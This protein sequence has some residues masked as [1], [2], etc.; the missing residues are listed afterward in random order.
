M[1][2]DNNIIKRL[3]FFKG[4]KTDRGPE[5]FLGYAKERLEPSRRISFNPL[6]KRIE[7]EKYYRWKKYRCKES[8]VLQEEPNPHIIIAGMSGLGKSSLLKS[9]IS[10]MK[11]NNITCV[12]F[13]S[14]SE[15]E[16]MVKSLGGRAFNAADFG[17]NIMALDGY[18]VAERIS[19][20]TT[21]FQRV[22]SLGSLQITK[23]NSCLW[24][25]YR[26]KGARSS[27]QTYM[28]KQPII[29]DLINE[30]N[31]F[32]RNARTKSEENTLLN[33]KQKLS[34][35]DNR[36]LQGT[37]GVEE[38]MNGITSFS[39][40]AIGSP[41]SR[42]IYVEEL[43][44]RLYHLMHKN[45]PNSGIKAYVVLDESQLVLEEKANSHFIGNMVEEG[46]KYG[47]GMIIVAHMASGLDRRIVAN[48][49]ALLSFFT[50]EPREVNYI[51]SV[52]SGGDLAIAELLKHK[53]GNLGKFE[54]IFAS[55]N[56]KLPI[57]L[58]TP[59]AISHY[60]NPKSAVI[61]N[62]CIEPVE[63]EKLKAMTHDMHDT[64][65]QQYIDSGIIDQF[66]YNGSKWLMKHN[67]SLSI[68]HEVYLRYISEKLGTCG[69]KNIL[70]TFRRGPDIIAGDVAIEYETGSK[71]II[72]T[73]AMLYKR[74]TYRK[75]IV[76]VNDN[77]LKK[78][79]KVNNAIS[80]SN[81]MNLECEKLHNMLD[82]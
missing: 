42:L 59:K 51:A 13:D 32:I 69:I 27:Q 82:I 14:N 53:I 34:V 72:D 60:S 57:L 70:N 18:T 17:I 81:F 50:K 44:S 9:I 24:Y 35:L 2:Y 45:T 74:Q 38:L 55:A 10:E 1:F 47:L 11:R 19:A 15:H 67:K 71:N 43:V 22:F 37:Q 39:I 41:E 61:A 56:S 6:A 64:E 25:V 3:P 73:I 20:L 30:L 28:E 48:S 7:N 23:L 29:K 4:K 75:T 12:L 52:L 78:Y 76:I 21:L 65:L 62:L 77:S 36:S 5:L 66:D 79:K 68:E 54:A 46:R 80:L 33:M 26:K 8:I 63:Y 58:R 16:S 31:I 40:S 49:S